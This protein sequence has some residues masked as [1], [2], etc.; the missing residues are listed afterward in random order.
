MEPR[1][2]DVKMADSVYLAAVSGHIVVKHGGE[3]YIRYFVER[4]QLY[5]FIFVCIPGAPRKAHLLFGVRLFDTIV[6]AVNIV[7]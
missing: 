5:W 6:A 1:P 3:N 7:V 2:G 4:N